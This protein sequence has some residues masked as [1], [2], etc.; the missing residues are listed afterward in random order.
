MSELWIRS[1]DKEMLIKVD[2]LSII[3]N[4]F[5]METINWVVSSG[6]HW[7]G[8]YSSKQRALEILDEIQGYIVKIEKYGKDTPE[9]LFVY[10][11]PKE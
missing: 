6:T 3:N 1:Q 8:H 2:E 7:L 5:D 10:Q 4:S 9:A 11:M